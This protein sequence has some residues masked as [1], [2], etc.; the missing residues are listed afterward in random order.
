MKVV[1][2][3]GCGDAPH[4]QKRVRKLRDWDALLH[5]HV[6]P[7]FGNFAARA[8]ETT[9]PAVEE[10]LHGAMASL[11]EVFEEPSLGGPHMPACLPV[12]HGNGFWDAHRLSRPAQVLRAT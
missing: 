4:L 11:E 8:E 5:L 9:I 2:D 6:Q 7:S 1:R 10:N 12:L 3:A